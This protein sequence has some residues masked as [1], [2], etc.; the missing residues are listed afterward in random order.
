MVIP[1]VNCHP[2]N[3]QF[4]PPSDF[5]MFETDALPNRE[6][7]SVTSSELTWRGWIEGVGDYI[8]LF[9]FL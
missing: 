7:G 4:K 1:K 8:I 6:V 3:N 5:N 9:I 2:I